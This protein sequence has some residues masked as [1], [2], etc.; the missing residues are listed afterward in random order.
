MEIGR[1]KVEVQAR[2]SV[3]N[4]SILES[5]VDEFVVTHIV[6]DQAAISANRA[7]V[8]SMQELRLHVSWAHDGS[9]IE[10]GLVTLD[11]G[12][13]HEIG[14]SGWVTVPLSSEVVSLST[15]DVTSISSGGIER[16]ELKTEIPSIIWDRIN[17]T[18]ALAGSEDAYIGTPV[19]VL[20]RAEL[21]YDGTPLGEGDILEAGSQQAIWD[22]DLDA[23]RLE[24][25]GEKPEEIVFSVTGGTQTTFGIT[26]VVSPPDN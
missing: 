11:G 1:H 6:I 10:S 8:G 23:F 3:D 16:F 14:S 7:N 9:P 4:L 21:E 20:F 2:N 25:L 26:I 13:T 15:L 24:Y 22:S 19:A 5:S 18:Q 12:S 17:I